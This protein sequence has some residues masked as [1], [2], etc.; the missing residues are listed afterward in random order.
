MSINWLLPVQ[1]K[2]FKLQRNFQQR[3]ATHLPIRFAVPRDRFAPI[4]LAPPPLPARRTYRP[5][6]STFEAMFN[7][8]A[9]ESV[10]SKRIYIGHTNDIDVRL[11]YH[12]SEY[13]KI[14][15][16]LNQMELKADKFCFTK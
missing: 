16:M 9:I 1:W 13:E 15:R 3:N 11:K 2:Y 7:V 6:G 5:E 8:Y 10:A 12:N 4:W 14:L